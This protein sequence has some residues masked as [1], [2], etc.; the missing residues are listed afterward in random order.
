MLQTVPDSRDEA[1]LDR[2]IS[3]LNQNDQPRVGDFVRFADGT[4]RRISFIT[5]LDWMPECDSVQTSDGGSWYLGNGYASFSGGLYG[6][7]KRETLTLTDERKLGSCWIFHHDYAQA[8]NGVDVKILWR[9]YDC[10]E[11]PTT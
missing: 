8:G 5:P 3:L 10:T 2:R 9:V 6:G 11:E 4:L 1:I 7:V